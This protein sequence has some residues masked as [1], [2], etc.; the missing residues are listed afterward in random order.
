MDHGFYKRIGKELLKYNILSI[1]FQI[2]HLFFNIQ[3][4]LPLNFSND[5]MWLPS[6]HVK[7]SR[8]YSIYESDNFIILIYLNF[9]CHQSNF[10]HFAPFY[11]FMC[12]RPPLFYI[13]SLVH[14]CFPLSYLGGLFWMQSSFLLELLSRLGLL[15]WLAI[16]ALRDLQP[17]TWT[18][19]KW[20][21]PK[22]NGCKKYAQ[23]CNTCTCT[24]P[25]ANPKLKTIETNFQNTFKH[26]GHTSFEVWLFMNLGWF[27][28]PLDSPH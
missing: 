3:C 27:F 21:T 25:K 22:T 9:F 15:L 24:W 1:R 7:R 4:N 17:W 28:V 2:F 13:P 10:S 6:I 16:V 8:H 12:L 26:I 19:I 23:K 14:A 20:T 5:P 18:Y 11:T